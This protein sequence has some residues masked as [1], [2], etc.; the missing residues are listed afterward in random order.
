[1]IDSPPPPHTK[2][3][4]KFAC[5]P[6]S[7]RAARMSP[8]TTPN[9]TPAG[10]C[11]QKCK[12]CARREEAPEKVSASGAVSCAPVFALSLTRRP[13]CALAR[14]RHARTKLWRPQRFTI[15]IICAFTR[16]A[17]VLA[18]PIRLS[19]Y[20]RRRRRGLDAARPR[21]V[22]RAR[23]CRPSPVARRPPPVGEPGRL[24][25]ASSATRTSFGGGGGRSA[26]YWRNALRSAPEIR[27]RA[28]GRSDNL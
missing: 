27:R 21:R 20:G 5:S 9:Y 17:R 28:S 24:E 2:R 1:M 8:K 10:R 12:I 18:P 22:T 26:M 6:A 11:G 7:L 23:I 14:R 4:R 13:K 15:V 3:T 19:D 25:G 16:G